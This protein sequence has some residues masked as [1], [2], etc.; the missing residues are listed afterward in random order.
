MFFFS[1]TKHAHFCLLD[2]FI[3]INFD[4]TAESQTESSSAME[5]DPNLLRRIEELELSVRS[6]NCL[7]NENIIYVGDLVQFSEDDMMKTPN[8]GKKSLDEIKQVL[9]SMNLYLGMNVP[10]W[11]PENIEKLSSKAHQRANLK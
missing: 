8:F 4:D 7:K 1:K 5:W 10:Y 9:R 3:F 11:P 2:S 6:M